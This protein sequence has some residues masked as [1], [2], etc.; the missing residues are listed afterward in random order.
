[1]IWSRLIVVFLLL[2]LAFIPATIAKKKGRRFWVW[3]TYGL[4]ILVVAIPH[5]LLIGKTKEQKA[6]EA[7]KAG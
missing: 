2:G 6:R 7:G 4:C 3:Y 1:M 5:A